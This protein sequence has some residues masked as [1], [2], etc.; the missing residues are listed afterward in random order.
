MFPT[1][2]IPRPGAGFLLAGLLLLTLPASTTAADSIAVAG[3][4]EPFLD[5]TLSASVPGIVTALKLKEGDAVQQGQ[6]LL[7]LDRKIEE[8]EVRRREIVRE[9]KRT[10]FEG[11]KK[12][13]SSTRGVSKEDLDKKEVEYHV[14]AVETDMAAEQLRRRQL[15]SP[16]TG[17]ISEI[18][19]DVGESCSAYQPLVRVVDTRRCYFVANVEARQADRLKPD[20]TLNLEIE[21]GADPIKVQ[22]KIS[23]LAPTVDP[24]SGLRRV[25][26]VFENV[27]G[28]VVPGVAGRLLI[29]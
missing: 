2:H 12:L 9:Q 1:I 7:E 24:A 19:I 3:I 22:A 20:Q 26:L 23:F 27:D 25:K 17:T 18:Q 11:T 8:L 28:R 4:T 16:L 10:D 15:L 21:S 14:A 13:F 6:V 5:V 29:E